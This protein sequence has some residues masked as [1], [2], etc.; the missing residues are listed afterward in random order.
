M[1]RYQY[2]ELNV[3]IFYSFLLRSL[4]LIAIDYPKSFGFG[5]VLPEYQ[6]FVEVSQIAMKML[7][8]LLHQSCLME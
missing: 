8:A 4:G 7:T 3:H 1:E 5:S 6:W 2:L